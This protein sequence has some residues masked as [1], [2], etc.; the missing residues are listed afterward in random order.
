MDITDFLIRIADNKKDSDALA[1]ITDEIYEIKY[2]LSYKDREYL[3]FALMSCLKDLYFEE[4]NKISKKSKEM[5]YK[6]REYNQE[7]HD[8]KKALTV[9]NPYAEYIVSGK[10]TIELRKRNTNY[11]GELIICSSQNPVLDGMQSGC[12]MGSVIVVSTK[13]TSQMTQEEWDLTM[14]PEDQRKDYDGY[15]W[16]LE[17]P[18]RMVEMPV[19]GQLGIWNLVVDD[20]D[21]IYYDEVKNIDVENPSYL[22]PKEAL[23]KNYSNI[24]TA[25]GCAVVLLCFFIFVLACMYIYKGIAK[26]LELIYG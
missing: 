8:I 24:V 14:V 25:R 13:P 16:F 9:K 4:L 6:Y 5:Q 22:N 2:I 26:L 20:T 23:K 3:H 12:I 11:R 17:S 19:K 18:R 1:D 15:G 21:F 7:R 10:K